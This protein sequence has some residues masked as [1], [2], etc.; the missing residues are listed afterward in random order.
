MPYL[1]QHIYSS[2]KC[3]TIRLIM[4]ISSRLECVYLLKLYIYKSRISLFNCLK[5]NMNILYYFDLSDF[6]R[7]KIYVI[8]Y[9]C[10]N[11]RYTACFLEIRRKNLYVKI[12]IVI[13][14]NHGN[15]IVAKPI[16]IV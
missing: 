8:Y 12:T 7:R 14:I 13:N 4:Q 6:N 5:T 16:L 15:W 2:Q 10:I 9:K 11:I 1:R 3:L